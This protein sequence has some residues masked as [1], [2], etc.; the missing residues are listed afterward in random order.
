MDNQISTNADRLI[1]YVEA[2]QEV[3]LEKASNAISLNNNQT[4][5]L[6]LALEKHG[7]LK[8]N[9]GLLGMTISKPKKTKKQQETTPQEKKE[10]LQ[11]IRAK[12]LSEYF[13]VIFKP[14]YDFKNYNL[15]VPGTSSSIKHKQP[16]WFFQFGI[17][18]TFPEIPRSPIKSD[19]VQLKHVITDPSSGRLMEV[20]GQP[21]WKRQ[22]PKVGEND[23]KLWRY[24]RK[25]RKKLNP[26]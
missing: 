24:K 18:I 10:G 21:I 20:R 13:R 15:S 1:Q 4:E 17:S 6:A 11:I 19:H 7:L 12:N 3:S 16:T 2:N 5:K 22:N 8:T 23:R 9:Y 26:Y 14:S 25:N